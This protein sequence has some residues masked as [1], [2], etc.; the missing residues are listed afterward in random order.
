MIQTCTCGEN[1]L[2][3]RRGAAWRR[4][5]QEGL[6][7][8]PA[9]RRRAAPRRAAR[10]RG[11]GGEMRDKHLSRGEK[12]RREKRQSEAAGGQPCLRRG[13]AANS[14]SPAADYGSH[15]S[16]LGGNLPRLVHYA[17]CFGAPPK[18]LRRRYS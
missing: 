18:P 7:S 9:E 14:S 2:P 4:G 16:E 6:Q 12:E 17:S 5:R 15:L 11:K 10:L 1:A 8:L 13:A 3:P